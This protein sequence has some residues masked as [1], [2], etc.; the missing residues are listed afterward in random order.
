MFTRRIARAGSGLETVL[1]NPDG[2]GVFF[3]LANT[4]GVPP[5]VDEA[6]HG[7]TLPLLE[8]QAATS[9]LEGRG[10]VYSLM[11]GMRRVCS[12]VGMIQSWIGIQSW[13]FLIQ[14]VVRQVGLV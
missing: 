11:I 5:E 10:M 6:I 12:V 3:K 13:R 9:G 14:L 8:S 1:A 7:S 4:F 2:L